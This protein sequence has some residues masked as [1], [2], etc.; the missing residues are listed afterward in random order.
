MLSAVWYNQNKNKVAHDMDLEDG[1][2]SFY[3]SWVD[4]T[5]C[6]G[7]IIYMACGVN[8]HRNC[9]S[10]FSFSMAYYLTNKIELQE[11]GNDVS[12]TK[13]NIFMIEFQDSL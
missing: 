13:V 3:D 5:W 2:S 7:I 9:L 6:E 12:H 11:K 10:W 8:I 4:V 1:C